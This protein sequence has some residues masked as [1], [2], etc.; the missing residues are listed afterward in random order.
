[1]ES[2][3][4]NMM[5]VLDR[6]NL[7]LEQRLPFSLVRI[8]DGENL[9]L[10]Q[11]SVWPMEAVLKERWAIKANRGQ[12]GLHLPNLPL[13]DAVRDAAAKAD[14]VGILP[15]EDTTILAPAYLKRQLTDQLFQ[16]YG[17]RPKAVCDARIN[18]EM[19]FS[20]T[21]W[22]V[23]T[24]RRIVLATRDPEPLRQALTA[25]PYL[26]NIVHTLPFGDYSQMD[27][28]L[29][30]LRQNSDTFDLA[31]FSCGVNAVVLAQKTA[32]LTGR[33]ALDFGKAANIILKGTPN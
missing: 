26:L 9:V 31:L 19:L 29:E 8:G 7:A 16:H 11:D 10:A 5:Q 18:R 14:V 27:A 2:I 22:S 1:M 3:P 32:E 20:Q 15:H 28:T 23:V 33:A 6:L 24:P 13:R 12:K 30:W 17:L 21:F 4:L 25:P